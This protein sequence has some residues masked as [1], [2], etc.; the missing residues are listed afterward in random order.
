VRDGSFSYSR[1]AGG[2]GLLGLLGLKGSGAA[3]FAV[4]GAHGDLE[5]TFNSSGQR[6]DSL[7]YTPFGAAA[8]ASGG[9]GAQLGFQGDWTDP[10]TGRV[11]MGARWYDP[12]NGRFLTRDD[13]SPGLSSGSD[14]NRYLYGA[15]NPLSNVDPNGHCW[16]G[17][18]GLQTGICLG[19]GS[20]PE[21][22]QY[23]P[24]QSWQSQYSGRWDGGQDMRPPRQLA[25]PAPAP[26]EQPAGS[27]ATGGSWG[28]APRWT[29]RWAPRRHGSRPVTYH[30]PPLAHGSWQWDLT[31]VKPPPLG[32]PDAGNGSGPPRLYLPDGVQPAASGAPAVGAANQQGSCQ[33]CKPLQ[34]GSGSG[35]PPPGAFNCTSDLMGALGGQS[36]EGL[37]GRLTQAREQVARLGQAALRSVVEHPTQALLACGLIPML[38]IPCNL[39]LAGIEAS[40][41]DYMGVL[42]SVLAAGA[43]LVGGATVIRG[44][45][46]GLKGA[47]ST[48]RAAKIGHAAEDVPALIYRG[49]SADRRI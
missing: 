46:T 17:G 19:Q 23:V 29:P 27:Q 11:W 12:G 25:Q 5:A 40:R 22:W 37:G 14:S 48:G 28:W 7:A 4:Q 39:A 42:F 2:R 10:L 32:S 38:G 16:I 6:V 24:S 49:G 8:G 31:K 20:A 21:Q 44:G 34:G 18:I 13:Y 43:D 35:A 26:A 41:G 47:T 45:E 33:G 1:S 3:L 36:Q 15:A 30:P 9:T